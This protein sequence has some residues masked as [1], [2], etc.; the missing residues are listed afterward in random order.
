LRSDQPDLGDLA[1]PAVAAAPRLLG[2]DQLERPIGG[3][4]ARDIELDGPDR[5]G[6][7]EQGVYLN[8]IGDKPDPRIEPVAGEALR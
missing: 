8:S 2:P 5:V 7:P 1:S 4:R 6:L 3:R